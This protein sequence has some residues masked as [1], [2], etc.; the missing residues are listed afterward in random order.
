MLRDFYNSVLEFIG[1][2]SLTD[3]EFELSPPDI[4]PD[5]TKDTYAFLKRIVSERESVSDTYRRLYSVYYAAG[6]IDKSESP[7]RR[8]ASNIFIGSPL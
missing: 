3:E 6:V 1:T 8:P 2:E 7:N 4:E 5:Y